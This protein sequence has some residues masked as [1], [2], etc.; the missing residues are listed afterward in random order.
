MVLFWRIGFATLVT[1]FY[2][3][4]FGNKAPA[5]GSGCTGCVFRRV[6]PDPG[7]GYGAGDLSFEGNLVGWFDRTFMPAGF[8]ETYDENALLTQLPAHCLTVLGQP[9]AMCC[10]S[11]GKNT[12]LGWLC[13]RGSYLYNG[14]FTMGAVLPLITFMDQFIIL[15]TGHGIFVPCL[16]LLA[17]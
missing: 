6:V 16:V 8:T 15:L 5:V 4:I 11:N 7:S 9:R 12:K 3:S 1:T 13:C 14:R 2:I 17:D 10:R